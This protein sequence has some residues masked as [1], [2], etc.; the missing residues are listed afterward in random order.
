MRVGSRLSV[1][2]AVVVI[3]SVIV[4]PAE[5]R[6]DVVADVNSDTA[7]VPHTDVH[8]VLLRSC[9]EHSERS[10]RSVVIARHEERLSP[11]DCC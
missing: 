7:T 11:A 6:L 8:T 4:N 9:S 10:R 1:D 2:I 5:L 3:V